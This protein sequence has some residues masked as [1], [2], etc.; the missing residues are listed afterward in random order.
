[1]RESSGGA[2]ALQ[3]RRNFANDPSDL[4]LGQSGNLTSVALNCVQTQVCG[5]VNCAQT[6]VCG[7]VNCAQTQVC[8][9]VN[10]VQ[11][12]VCGTVNCVQTQPVV[13]VP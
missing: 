9:T 4:F 11:T 3:L 12:Q 2:V 5:T 13:T 7:T 1:M 6:Q 8:G 10:C